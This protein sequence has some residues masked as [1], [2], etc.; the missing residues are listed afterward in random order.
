[1]NKMNIF[2]ALTSALVIDGEVVRA[3]NLVEVSEAEAKN[4]LHRGKARLATAEDGVPETA[5]EV[6]TNLG[7]M[8]KAQLLDFAGTN[9]LCEVSDSMTKA[10]ILA[11]IEASLEV[12]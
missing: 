4:F 12:E 9:Q 3:G 2:L 7:K 11:A 5:A 8:T 1:M 6:E 10:D